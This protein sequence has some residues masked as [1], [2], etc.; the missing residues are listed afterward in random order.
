MRSATVRRA[1]RPLALAA[2]LGASAAHAHVAPSVD[3]N[4]RYLKLTPLAD[5]VR[6]AYTVYYGEVPGAAARRGIDHNRDGAIDDDEASAFGAAL[7]K[8]VGPALA[9]TVDGAPAP[10][11]WDQVSVGMGTPTTSAGAFSVDLIAWLCLPTA[12]GDHTIT[13]VDTFALQRPGETELRIEDS[14]GVR[15]T[16]ARL[17]PIDL[18]DHDARWQGAGGPIAHEGFTLGFTADDARP[19]AGGACAGVARAAGSRAWMWIAALAALL[20][21]GAS[22]IVLARRRAP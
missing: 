1:A 18:V 15:V 5:R 13:L 22:V 3:D 20:V 7:G 6:L 10:I 17:G 8:Q 12:G 4:N 9:I 21:V 19:I 11:A 14:A 2:L 16:R